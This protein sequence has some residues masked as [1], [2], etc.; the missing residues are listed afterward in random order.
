VTWPRF[1]LCTELTEV[2]AHAR[3][4]V[5]VASMLLDIRFD[6]NVGCADLEFERLRTFGNVAVGFLVC[7]FGTHEW[8]H[9]FHLGSMVWM[10]LHWICIVDLVSVRMVRISAHWNG[11]HLVVCSLLDH[12]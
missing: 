12:S 1:D 2:G 5:I 4:D 6:A 8:S 7:L 11:S 10:K 3:V 9:G